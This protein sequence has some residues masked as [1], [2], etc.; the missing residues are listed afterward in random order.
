MSELKNRLLYLYY[1]SAVLSIILI[2]Y[3]CFVLPYMISAKDDFL[4]IGGFL[5]L[6]ILL[7]IFIVSGV[8]I[9]K[10]IIKLKKFK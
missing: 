4:V 5:S 3:L 9:I 6:I 7:P 2:S 8:N 10:E 1:R